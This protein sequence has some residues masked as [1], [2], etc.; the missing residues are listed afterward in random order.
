MGCLV[1]ERGLNEERIRLAQLGYLPGAPTTWRVIDS[2]NV[3]CGILIPWLVDD[4]V[5]GIKVRRVA[6]EQ[7]YQAEFRLVKRFH[8][9]AAQKWPLEH[10]HAPPKFRQ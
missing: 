8:S 3:L 7:R 10:F 5:W 2:L 1:W 6:G 4:A 9:S